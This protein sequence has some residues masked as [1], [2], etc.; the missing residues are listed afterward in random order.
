MGQ[1]VPQNYTS[2]LS[3]LQLLQYK[4]EATFVAVI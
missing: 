3:A 2:S 4:V 1:D